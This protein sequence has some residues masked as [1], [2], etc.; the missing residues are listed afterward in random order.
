MNNDYQGDEFQIS[1]LE[2]E[3]YKLSLERLPMC[4][5]VLWNKN[6]APGSR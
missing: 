1:N 4:S 2:N 6:K 5:F 3:F